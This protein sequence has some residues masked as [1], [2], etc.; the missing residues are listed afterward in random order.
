VTVRGCVLLVVVVC[1]ACVAP[2]RAAPSVISSPPSSPSRPVSIGSPAGPKLGLRGS[3]PEAAPALA[4]DLSRVDHLLRA[5][6]LRFRGRGRRKRPA[7]ERRLQLEGLRQQ[8]IYRHLASNP[9]VARRVRSMVGGEIRQEMD[10]NLAAA[11]DLSSLVAP[12]RK[13]PKYEFAR[14][15][16]PDKLRK[17]YRDAQRRFGVPWYVLAAVNFVESKFGRILGPSSSGAM[18]PMQFLPSTFDAYGTG[19]IN[20]PHDSIVAAA[21]YLHASGAP[22]KMGRALFAYNR[23]AAYV[24]AILRYAGRMRS[25]PWSFW[26]Y[27]EYQVFVSTTEGAVRLTGPGTAHPDHTPG[28]PAPT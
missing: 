7:L 4:R 27:Y 26:A 12:I 1:S 5:D 3:F 6:V 24:D 20:D 25:H 15:A 11:K 13:I 17:L 8:E 19:D 14:P 16:S 10:A 22:E 18:G 2:D 9:R 21:R 28:R 23:A